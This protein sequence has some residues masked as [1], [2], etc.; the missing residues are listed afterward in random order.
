M[1]KKQYTVLFIVLIVFVGILVV[2]YAMLSIAHFQY[3]SSASVNQ[4][5]RST[6]GKHGP[7]LYFYPN[8]CTQNQKNPNCCECK[9]TVFKDSSKT[10][11]EEITI[12]QHC[13]SYIEVI[14]YTC[15]VDFACGNDKPCPRRKN[16]GD[17]EENIECVEKCK[18]NGQCSIDSYYR[19]VRDFCGSECGLELIER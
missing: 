7:Y 9:Y 16:A 8:T 19:Q 13:G 4:L 17:L 2:Q 3:K 11:L 5:Q 1:R 14:N 10:E 18:G 15:T 6:I 12:A